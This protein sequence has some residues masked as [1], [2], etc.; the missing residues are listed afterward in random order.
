MT[1]WAV[2]RNHG[3]GA[4]APKG[5]KNAWKH[6]RYSEEHMAEMRRLRDLLREARK[7]D[8]L[9]RGRF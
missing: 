1:G 3:A 9:V 4:G 8:G 7:V 5:N 2:C 6:G